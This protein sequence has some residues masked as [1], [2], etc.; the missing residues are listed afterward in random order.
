MNDKYI[1]VVEI[2]Q[3]I[4]RVGSI[5]DTYV[6]RGLLPKYKMKHKE[7]TARRMTRYWDKA[8]VLSYMPKVAEYQST[9]IASK[10]A[11]ES[12]KEQAKKKLRFIPVRP[13]ETVGQ[14]AAR[15]AFR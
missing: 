6:K 2:S 11:T 14:K 9:S 4:G 13:P 5:V 12:Q 15:L 8:E 10:A 1:T 7:S 3:M